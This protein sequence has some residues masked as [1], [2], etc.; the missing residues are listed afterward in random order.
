M[1]GNLSL[2]YMSKKLYLILGFVFFV[3]ILSSCDK[4]TNSADGFDRKPLLE[5]Y[6]NNLIIPAWEEMYMQCDS[7]H[8]ASVTFNQFPT[9]DNLSNVKAKLTKCMYSYASVSTYNFGPAETTLGSY[10]ENNGTFP[11]NASKIEN[12]ISAKNYSHSNFDRDS[13]GLYGI[14]YLLFHSDPTHIVAEF[15]SDSIRGK[16]LVSATALLTDDTK[17][18]FTDWNSTYREIFCNNNGTSAGS[19]LSLLYNNM[20]L[21]YEVCKNY[22]LGLPLGRMAGQ[23]APEPNRVEALYAGISLQLLKAQ[24]QNFKK[25][26]YGVDKNGGDGKGFDDY[27]KSM[28]SGDELLLEID[29]QTHLIDSALES[30]PNETLSNMIINGNPQLIVLHTEMQKLTRFIKSDMSSLLGISITFSSGDGD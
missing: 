8:M 3:G 16:Y 17:T 23:T 1:L 9:L 2:S 24:F 4:L 11:A 5:N 18:V 22:R 29:Q 20:I 27:L 14:E 15:L 19:S 25:L 30:L 28:E 13:R 10:T 21:N 6:A 12:F 7:L 26:M